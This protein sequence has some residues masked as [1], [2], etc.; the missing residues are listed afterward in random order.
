M[1]MLTN[2]IGWEYAEIQVFLARIRAAM[3]NKS[4]HGYSLW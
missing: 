3:R 2:V 4:F 1:Y